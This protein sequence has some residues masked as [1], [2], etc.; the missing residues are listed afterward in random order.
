M[1]VSI[2]IVRREIQSSRICRPFYK[3][4][5][6]ESL[7]LPNTEKLDQD[8]KGNCYK[9]LKYAVSSNNS[10]SVCCLRLYLCWRKDWCT[11]DSSKEER[12]RFRERFS[13]TSLIRGSGWRRGDVRHRA[14]GSWSWRKVV[15][16]LETRAEDFDKM[17]TNTDSSF[18]R[19]LPT[20]PVF[21]SPLLGILL[22]RPLG[23]ACP[24]GLAGSDLRWLFITEG[25]PL[26]QVS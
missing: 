19:W 23:L 25:F 16:Q 12:E 26:A 11:S 21:K 17:S 20:D 6:G 1:L 18:W 5:V 15:Q 24:Q 3:R 22:R 9:R 8:Y 13:M 14:A 7:H 10:P 2:A 4:P